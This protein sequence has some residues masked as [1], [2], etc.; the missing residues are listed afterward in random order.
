[1]GQD[2]AHPA[3]GGDTFQAMITPASGWILVGAGTFDWSESV[4]ALPS[5]EGQRRVV[6]DEPPV[7]GGD[8]SWLVGRFM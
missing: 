5:V 6:G 2:G 8:S 7:G 3:V 4:T 1:V